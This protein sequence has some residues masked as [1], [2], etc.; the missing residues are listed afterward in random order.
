MTWRSRAACL[1]D[2]VD[3]GWFDT[4]EDNVPPVEAMRICVGCPVRLPCL[5]TALETITSDDDGVW[6][7]TTVSNRTQIRQQRMSKARAMALGDRMAAMRTA[8]ERRADLE[9]WLDEECA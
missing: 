4:D 7:G 9:P 2:N 8:A 5:Q 6:G 3:P 1:D